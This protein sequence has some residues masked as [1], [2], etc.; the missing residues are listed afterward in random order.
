M[1][2]RLYNVSIPVI[3]MSMKPLN[4][5]KIAEVTGGIYHG[6]ESQKEQQ[7]ASV[8]KDHREA[9]VNSLFV[10]FI[11]ERVNGHDFVEHA[12]ENGAI[13]CL[14]QKKI[15]SSHPY[16]LV[17]SVID[18]LRLLAEYYRSLFTIPVIGI[19]GSVGKTTTKEMTAAVL[20]QKYNILKTPGNSNNEIGVPLTLLSLTEEH[21][22]AVIEMGISEFGEMS[23]LAQ[24]VRPD[25]CIMTMIGYSHMENLKDLAGV[26]KAKSEVLSFMSSEGV[27]ILNGDDEQL[28]KIHV[29]MKKITFGLSKSN[30]FYPEDIK[31]EGTEGLFFSISGLVQSS[32][33]FLPAFGVQ[34]IPAALAAAAVGQLFHIEADQ[35]AAGLRN[36]IPSGSRARICKTSCITILDDCYNASPN[37]VLAALRSL[38]TISGRKTAIL[39][40]ML[41]L[42]DLETEMH[43]QVGN[44]ASHIGLDCLICC[45]NKAEMI[46]R[47]AVANPNG[48]ETWY[49]PSKNE[50]FSELPNLLNRNDTVLVK[51]AH[52]MHFEEIV[53]VLK[54][55][56]LR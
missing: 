44:L 31:Q 2:L 43:R 5:K 21:E 46:Y 9:T 27:L 38:S 26:L 3:K 29:N 30:M 35:I 28:T 42:G 47:N 12:F 45:G 33:F 10:C 11:G 55:L 52:S 23:R 39:G 18:A 36:Y 7:I 6:E 56:D 20:A 34:L 40:D 16:I 4:L 48:M 41:E 25:I 13:C 32:Q 22:A 37:S 19:T 15:D 14:V 24:M 8:V 53:D 51:A 17:T 49:F 1:I 50:L 54:T